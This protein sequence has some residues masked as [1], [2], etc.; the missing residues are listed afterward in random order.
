GLFLPLPVKIFVEVF[1]FGEFVERALLVSGGVIQKSKL[2][3]AVGAVRTVLDDFLRGSFGFGQII[4]GH[5]LKHLVTVVVAQ[6]Q[7]QQ[8]AQFSKRIRIVIHIDI[9]VAVIVDVASAAFSYHQHGGGLASARVAAG[10]ISC[11]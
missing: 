2:H 1:G 7:I 5:G 6:I 3:V 4:G 9:N 11:F 10:S 8:A